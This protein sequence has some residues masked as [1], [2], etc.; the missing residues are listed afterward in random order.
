ME[1][2]WKEKLIN[3]GWSVRAAA[4]FAFAWAKSTLMKYNQIL[5]RLLRFSLDCE[6]TF[7]PPM[8]VVADFLCTVTDA[9]PRPNS[10]LKNAMAAMSL[11]YEVYGL[12]IPASDPDIGRLRIALVKSGTKRPAIGVKVMPVSPF[13]QL[14]VSW[15][16][17][18]ELSVKLLR[19]K[20][21]TLMALVFMTR[22]SDL[23][24]KAVQFDQD[25]FEA[26]PYVLSADHVTF[27]ED[28]YLEVYFFG[29]KN[30][31]DRS[32]FKV[33]VPPASIRKIDPGAALACYIHR[34]EEMR[35]GLEDRPL[36]VSLK[37]P[38]KA[39]QAGTISNILEESI[40]LA[41]L[42]GQGFSAKSFRP[43]GATAAVNMGVDPRTA[44]QIGRW[45][46]QEVFFEH[47][48]FP[49]APVSYT[50]NILAGADN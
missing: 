26:V 43:T 27:R 48:V 33:V 18:D 7:P 8:P 47:Y 50:T 34:T 42:A 11:L 9:S 25:T 16:E 31:M 38:Y 44:M 28:G 46:T 2:L 10:A 22:P 1:S 39:I 30:D 45:K 23:A 14:F 17:N 36:F 37:K 49:R 12:P 6:V 3:K 13:Y 40:L 20:C 21:V 4:Q 32:G 5:T 24:P 15:P 41:G 29:I 35:N 19:L